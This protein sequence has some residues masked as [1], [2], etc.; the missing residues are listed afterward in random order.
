[1][2]KSLY[3][4]AAVELVRVLQLELIVLSPDDENRVE[5]LTDPV[6]GRLTNVSNLGKL[7][8]ERNVRPPCVSVGVSDG[9][10]RFMREHGRRRIY[11]QSVR[12]LGSRLASR[13]ILI[14]LDGEQNVANIREIDAS[15]VSAEG[16]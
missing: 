12:A 14:W 9:L 2:G 1:M 15:V 16:K 4:C 3:V 13:D 7:L 6:S 5:E 8:N 10:K 11:Q